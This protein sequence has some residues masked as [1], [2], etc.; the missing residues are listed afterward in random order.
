M[1]NLTE[2]KT[3]IKCT[4][5]GN[6]RLFFFRKSKKCHIETTISVLESLLTF[7]NVCWHG[8]GSLQT[9]SKFK[10]VV[11]SARRISVGCDS[12]ALQELYECV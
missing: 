6:Q 7:C 12:L 4:K 3:S 10:R 1:T 11:S 5:E 9:R 2:M 8:N